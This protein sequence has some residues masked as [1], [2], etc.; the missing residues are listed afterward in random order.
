MLS[1]SKKLISD[2]FDVFVD[3]KD[4][5][6]ITKRCNSSNLVRTQFVVPKIGSKNF[7]KFIIT[8]K[9]GEYRTRVAQGCK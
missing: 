8:F 3:A 5:L 6:R 9:N 2:T 7:G 4:F 1:S